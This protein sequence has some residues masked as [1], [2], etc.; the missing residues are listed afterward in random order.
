MALQQRCVPTVS[1]LRNRPFH[2]RLTALQKSRIAV[3]LFDDT[4]MRLEGTLIVRHEH[5]IDVPVVIVSFRCWNRY[6]RP[7]AP[8]CWCMLLACRCLAGAR[9]GRNGV[10]LREGVTF[11]LP[12]HKRSRIFLC[13]ALMST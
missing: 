5:R 8:G 12:F 7:A 13:R 6:V 10:S 2:A 4:S 3:W 1:S 11:Y 9:P